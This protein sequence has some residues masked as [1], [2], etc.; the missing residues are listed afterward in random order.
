MPNGSAN[1]YLG[2]LVN[3]EMTRRGVVRAG[4]LSA[5]VLG[6]GV[7]ASSPAAAH[8]SGPPAAHGDT[9]PGAG[10]LTDKPIPANRLDTRVHR[11]PQSAAMDHSRSQ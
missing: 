6:A 3:A 5:L 11:L 9:A 1:K 2:D 7:T 10:P 8:G 4:A